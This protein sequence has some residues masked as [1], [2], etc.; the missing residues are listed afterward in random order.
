MKNSPKPNVHKKIV[1]QSTTFKILPEKTV[2]LIEK[3]E[4]IWNLKNILFEQ[5]NVMPCIF[6]LAFLNKD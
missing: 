5:E 6:V 2:K 4:Q 3:I 1:G